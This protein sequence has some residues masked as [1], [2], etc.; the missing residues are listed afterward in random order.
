VRPRIRDAVLLFVGRGLLMPF[1]FVSLPLMTT[2]LPPA[3][4]GRMVMVMAIQGW[5]SLVLISPVGNYVNRMFVEWNAR[6]TLA[7][8]L[9][10]FAGYVAAA[11]AVASVAAALF[12]RFI[13]VG[14]TI[15]LGWLVT[16]VAGHLFV[17]TLYANLSTGLN[18][19]GRRSWYVG[20]TV[21]SAWLGLWGSVIAA[22]LFAGTA[23]MWLAGQLAVEAVLVVV[24]VAALPFSTTQVV[25][26]PGQARDTLRDAFRFAWPLALGVTLYWVQ[27]QAYPFLLVGPYGTETVGMLA[28]GLG[29]G[30]RM[31]S[32]FERFYSDLYLPSYYTS[33]A[34]AV[35]EGRAEAW[36]AYGTR[37]F[38]SLAVVGIV[39]TVVGPILL[40]F[41]TPAV[42][43]DVAWLAAW[44]GIIEGL[45]IAGATI[46]LAFH[47]GLHTRPLLVPSTVSAATVLVGV[48]VVVFTRIEPLLGTS[49]VLV[50]AGALGAAVTWMLAARTLKTSLDFRLIGVA[51]VAAMPAAI[52]ALAASGGS[53][54]ADIALL[55]M[56]AA[57]TVAL[58]V[59]LSGT[60]PIFRGRA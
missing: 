22:S 1:A 37:L 49:L 25:R 26:G 23:E 35:P 38:A 33:L 12:E 46:A 28:V 3:E 47:G 43:H 45:R 40:R 31:L 2:L 55:A 44:G 10:R 58:L 56:V 14:I 9:T 36:N 16:L 50:T 51:S 11:A 52:M 57:Y 30:V 53:T 32:A 15:G 54:P 29:V 59:L 4:I 17:H 48:G 18:L 6:G 8:D 27:V 42:Y 20:L 13:G 5:F 60:A 34:S 24:A 39:S 41:L 21:A 19:L 7:A